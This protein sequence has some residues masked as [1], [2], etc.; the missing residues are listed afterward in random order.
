MFRSTCSLKPEQWGVAE[1]E[2]L[3]RIIEL[4]GQYDQL[5]VSNIACMEAAARRVQTIEWA[6]HD[7]IR[8]TDA[9]STSRLSLEEATAFSG[10]SRAG[11]LLMVAPALLD[12]VKVAV[13]KDAAIMKN[14]RKA[15]EER[16]LRR[17]DH[18]NNKDKYK[19]KG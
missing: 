10:L 3:L 13:E 16:E 18:N 17:K 14:I 15:R 2:T 19:D 7:K 11:D 1:H 8:E 12:H 4:A 6:Y 5:D 9:G